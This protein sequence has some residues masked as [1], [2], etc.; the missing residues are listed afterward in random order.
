MQWN[1]SIQATPTPLTLGGKTYTSGFGTHANSDICVQTA[2]PARRLKIVAGVDDNGATSSSA[3]APVAFSIRVGDKTLWSCPPRSSSQGAIEADVDLEGATEFHLIAKTPGESI[4]YAH[5]DWCQPML[6]LGDGTTIELSRRPSFPGAP[7]RPP[8]SFRYDGKDSSEL[9]PTWQVTR[10]RSTE[11]GGITVHRTTYKGPK[12]QLECVMELR[13]Y[14][15][16]PAARWVIHFR[17]AGSADTPIIED[18]RALDCQWSTGAS[19][20]LF[21]AKGSEG[22]A[23]DFQCFSDTI[24]SM[25]V[26]MPNK[27]LVLGSVGG[28]PTS[29]YLPFFNLQDGG[30]GVIIGLGWTGQWS[31]SF[32]RDLTGNTQI[33]A[34]MEKTHLLLHPGEEIRTPSV[35]AIYWQGESIRGNN[36]LRQFI[37]HHVAPRPNGQIIQAPLALGAW[38]GDLTSSQLETIARQTKAGLRFDIFWVDAGWF[39]D[40]GGKPMP[41]LTG[42]WYGQAGNWNINSGIHPDGFAE[43]RKAARDAGMGMLLWVEPE[44][45][46]WGSPITREHPEWFLGDKAQGS[47]VLLNLGNPQ[48]RHWATDLV[49]GLIKQIDLTWYRQDF[50]MDCLEQWRSNDAPD[51]Q[52]M[53]EIRHVEGLYAFWDELLQR[54]PG[55][56]IDNCASGGRRLDLEMMARS[57]PLWRT[58]YHCPG[59]EHDPMAGQVHTMGLSYWLPLSGTSAWADP[60]DSYT[61]RSNLTAAIG[62]GGPGDVV[63]NK[64]AQQWCQNMIAQY[65]QARPFFY[66]DYCPLTKTSSSPDTWAA[67]QFHRSDLDAGMIVMLRRVESPFPSAQLKLNGVDPSAKYEFTDADSGE[68]VVH[69]GQDAT[70]G[71]ITWTLDKPRSSRL[72]FYR[73]VH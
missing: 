17:N 4:R 70:S 65:R 64:A 18:I 49:S 12:T 52:G 67:Y 66:G 58:D 72:V 24:P 30:Q 47:S 62:F 31:A 59:R 8:F 13:E 15:D 55:L 29:R 51:R 73:K 10:N 43:V 21:Y 16:F 6:T 27:P 39:G 44:R 33:Q 35:L 63:T 60:L 32:V 22:Q 41:E 36:L 48:A 37:L 19:P 23:D 50:N 20:S 71:G 5:A 11:P 25:G 54:H 42:H 1:Q 9:L 28:R 61:F 68:T 56:M 46:I 34:G 2:V 3:A 38:G 53:T 69:S 45:A 57:I 40:S 7:V 14:A 26:D